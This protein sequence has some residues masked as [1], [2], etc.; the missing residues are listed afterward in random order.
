MQFL[1]FQKSANQQ[2]Q[3]SAE[4]AECIQFRKNCLILVAVLSEKT[5]TAS[6]DIT[7]DTR[8]L[9]RGD[10]VLACLALQRQTVA[11]N[12]EYTCQALIH[13]RLGQDTRASISSI[14]ITRYR[15]EAESQERWCGVVVVSI[16]PPGQEMQST[17]QKVLVTIFVGARLV[18]RDIS[19]Q[20]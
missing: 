2:N 20:S 15:W 6:P 4:S 9:A 11:E 13:G 5:H 17:A 16:Q 7:F 12:E 3:Q 19:S 14:S 10:L 18:S 8:Y 1:Q